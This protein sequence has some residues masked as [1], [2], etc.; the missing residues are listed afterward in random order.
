MYIELMITSIPKLLNATYAL[1]LL[2]FSI[3]LGILIGLF[4]QY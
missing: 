4:L 1:K 3:V 2:S